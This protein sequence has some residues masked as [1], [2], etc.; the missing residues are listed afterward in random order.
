MATTNGQL[1]F[2]GLRTLERVIIQFVPDKLSLSRGANVSGLNVIGRNNPI[3]HFTGGETLLDFDLDFHAEAQDRQDVITKVKWLEALCYSD[4]RE[5]PPEK[6]KL[7]FG[8]IFR[9]EEWSVV[10]VKYDLSLFDK[11]FGFLPRQANVK[12]TLKLDPTRNIRLNDVKWT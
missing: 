3:Y 1:Y 6:I 11:Q 4:G 2:I 7:V 8:S 12:V 10:S 5:Y 9:D